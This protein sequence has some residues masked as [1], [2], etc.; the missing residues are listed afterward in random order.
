MRIE[1][2]PSVRKSLDRFE[3]GA[4]DLLKQETQRAPTY[5]LSVR[6]PLYLGSHEGPF[7]A[8]SEHE[9]R[10]HGAKLMELTAQG[11]GQI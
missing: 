9:L 3:V 6:R 8:A 7:L 11:S 2:A 1:S 4:C 10:Y 5:T